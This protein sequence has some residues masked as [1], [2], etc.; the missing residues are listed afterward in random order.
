MRLS[1]AKTLVVGMKRSGLAAAE[2]LAARGADVLATDLKP[3]DQL[4]KAAEALARIGARFEVQSPAVFEGRDLIVLSPGVPPDAE[5][6]HQARARGIRVIGEVELA[7]EF[8][9]GP[10]IGITGSNGKTTTTALTGH[11]LRECGIPVQV[12]GNIGTAVTAM[13]TS[14]RA[15]QW[16]VIELSSFQLETIDRFRSQIGVCLNVTPDHLDRH[17]TFAAYAAAKARLFETQLSTDF[18]VLNA[19]DPQCVLFASR[20]AAR[21]LWFSLTR[22]MDPGVWLEKGAVW[23]D[24]Q[25]IL[26]ANEIPIRGRHNIENT[27]AAIAAARL[28]GA[29]TEPIA[30]AVRT[31]RAVEHRLEFVRNIAGVDFYNDSKATNVDATLKAIEAFEGRLWVILGGKDKG[32][33]YTTLTPQLKRK[34]HAA[35]LI[36]AAAKII[37]TQLGGQVPLIESGTLDAAVREAFHRSSPGDTILLAPAC[38]SFDQ[39]EDYEHRGRAFKQ[40]VEGLAAG[41]SN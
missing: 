11:I 30:A 12:G 3:L 26:G 9:Q 28:A 6:L 33:D 27:M 41:R 21:P 31:F 17:H 40:I 7:A 10:I 34:A 25:R 2:L 15:N 38:A 35:L 32:S 39:F 22:A 1:G 16:N 37:E 8:L 23:F 13:I 19:D 4:P 18:A 5:P 20:T 29:A 36:G 24:S 14:S